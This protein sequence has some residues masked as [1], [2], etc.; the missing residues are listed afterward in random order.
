MILQEYQCLACGYSANTQI[1]IDEQGEKSQ[2]FHCQG[3]KSLIMAS[4]FKDQ[5][6]ETSDPTET[7][8]FMVCPRCESPN[9]KIWDY[10]HPCPRC[11]E[12]MTKPFT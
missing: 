1:T 2:T 12:H 6:P 8:H 10:K 9:S 3:C 5:H 4:D 7:E 11:G